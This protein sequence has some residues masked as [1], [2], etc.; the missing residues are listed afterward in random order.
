MVLKK[1]D[2]LRQASSKCD[3]PICVLMKEQ[4]L[5]SE[6]LKL[7]LLRFDSRNEE[8]LRLIAGVVKFEISKNPKLTSSRSLLSARTIFCKLS[9]SVG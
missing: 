2:R 4:S 3:F 6:V 8:P 1:V 5:R 7:Q 9:L